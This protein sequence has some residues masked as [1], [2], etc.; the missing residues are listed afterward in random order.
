M[1]I[2][3]CS[4]EETSSPSTPSTTAAPPRTTQAAAPRY[5]FSE[6]GRQLTALVWTDD[7]EQLRLA[8]RE[9]TKNVLATHAEGGYFLNLDCGIGNDP[10]KAANRLAVAKIAVGKL[11]AAQTGLAEG[12]SSIDF[13]TGRTCRED[14]TPATFDPNRQLDKDYAVEL[15]RGKIE[16][17]YVADQRPVKLANVSTTE[18]GG[19]WTTTG[20]AQ[21][22]SKTGGDMALVTFECVSTSGPLRTELTKF[23]VN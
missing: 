20:K 11:G 12:K 18:A 2:A 7:T 14:Q 16:E 1:G 15:C 4:A 17:K 19:R 9:I 8:Y 21:G 5:E 22:A 13:N 6:K 3:G 10:S 23:N